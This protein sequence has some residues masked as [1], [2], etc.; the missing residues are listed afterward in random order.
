M[1]STG[2]TS[3]HAVSFV[4]TQG[5]A[6]TYAIENLL[7]G[8]YGTETSPNPTFAQV[9]RLGLYHQTTLCT[10]RFLH[11]KIIERWIHAMPRRIGRIPG[12]G[13]MRS[14]AHRLTSV[15]L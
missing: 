12:T 9:R 7:R 14:G 3:T 15:H 8:V 4:P 1:Q 10:S 13:R 11:S 2:H 6:I 5:S